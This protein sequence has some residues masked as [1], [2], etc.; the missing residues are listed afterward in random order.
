LN[1]LKAPYPRLRMSKG[2]WVTDT[3]SGIPSYIIS[4]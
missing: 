4:K 2:L 3:F 1:R